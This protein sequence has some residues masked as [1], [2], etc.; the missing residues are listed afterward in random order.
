MTIYVLTWAS[1]ML[2]I[3]LVKIL[4]LIV[5]KNKVVI[6]GKIINVSF[7]YNWDL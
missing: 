7:N 2:I 5:F 6:E 4:P 3:L 1:S